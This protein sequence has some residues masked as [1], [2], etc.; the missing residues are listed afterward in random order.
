MIDLS[1]AL[2]SCSYSVFTALAALA[3]GAAK[4]ASA[5]EDKAFA[6]NSRKVCAKI[7]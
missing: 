4:P 2:K 6:E 3:L 5:Q 7:R 1:K